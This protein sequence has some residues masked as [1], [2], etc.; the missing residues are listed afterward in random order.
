[1][2]TFQE[3]PGDPRGYFEGPQGPLGA[4]GGPLRGPK[5]PLWDF[6]ALLR[7]YL[8]PLRGL[9]GAPWGFPGP[10]GSFQDAIGALFHLEVSNRF[11]H[12]SIAHGMDFLN[13]KLVRYY[14]MNKHLIK[15]QQQRNN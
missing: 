3:P 5:K 11:W 10:L 4:L 2:G 14:Q 7:N 1:M 13:T 12:R 9:P 8:K 6:Q 15:H